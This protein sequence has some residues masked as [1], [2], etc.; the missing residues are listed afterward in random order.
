MLAHSLEAAPEGTSTI[1][2]AMVSQQVG[3]L[4][5]SRN[6]QHLRRSFAERYNHCLHLP[7]VRKCQESAPQR[8]RGIRS[9]H[10]LFAQQTGTWHFYS[11]FC[12]GQR[13]RAGHSAH[14][15]RGLLCWNWT[16]IFHKNSSELHL[17][18]A[19]EK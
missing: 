3:V 11:G 5:F 9:P 8:A 7:A 10:F 2:L 18:T 16:L 13:F 12:Q 15:K 6:L 14:P 1:Q 4:S 19:T 17:S